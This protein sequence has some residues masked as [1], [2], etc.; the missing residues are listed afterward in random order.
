[1]PELIVMCTTWLLWIVNPLAKISVIDLSRALAA[2]AKYHIQSPI[3]FR[4]ES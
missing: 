2:V 4:S 3:S 1:M